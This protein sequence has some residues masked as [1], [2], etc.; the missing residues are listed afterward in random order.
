MPQTAEHLFINCMYGDRP[1]GRSQLKRHLNVDHLDFQTLMTKHTNVATQWVIAY[2]GLD[3]F[4]W[5]REHEQN[6]FVGKTASSE[7]AVSPEVIVGETQG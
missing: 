4:K 1:E 3:Q 7:A 5:A 2:F 6:I